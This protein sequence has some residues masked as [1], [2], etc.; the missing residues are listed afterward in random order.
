[1]VCVYG[2]TGLCGNVWVS[3]VCAYVGSCLCRPEELDT[4]EMEFQM[5]VSHL[6]WVLGVEL[7]SSGALNY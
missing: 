6:M 7:W 3:W 5:L 2:G 1:M 4:L